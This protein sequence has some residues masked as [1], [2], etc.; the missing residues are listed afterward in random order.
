MLFQT[1]EAMCYIM[2]NLVP[3]I[4]K[5]FDTI[6]KIEFHFEIL[7]WPF[8]FHLKFLEFKI[9]FSDF[10]GNES[11]ENQKLLFGVLK[12]TRFG[13]SRKLFSETSAKHDFVSVLILSEFENTKEF[14]RNNSEG[15]SSM[16]ICILIFLSLSDISTKF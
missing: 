6:P 3:D 10:S 11:K 2:L 15:R 4:W 16:H 9:A 5:T 12:M 1:W 14:L 13:F 8:S 7:F